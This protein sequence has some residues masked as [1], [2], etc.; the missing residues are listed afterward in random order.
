MS[1]QTEIPSRKPHERMVAQAESIE[2]LLHVSLGR[3]IKRLSIPINDPSYGDSVQ[4]GEKICV[5][6]LKCFIVSAVCFLLEN[7]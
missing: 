5:A 1:F 4:L 6:A 3:G 2:V 7:S